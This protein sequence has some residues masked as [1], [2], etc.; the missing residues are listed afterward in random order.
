MAPHR[1][2][3]RLGADPLSAHASAH[4]RVRRL[5]RQPIVAAPGDS[6]ALTFLSQVLIGDSE[7]SLAEVRQL[8]A[9][10]ERARFDHS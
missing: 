4:R 1:P 5:D 10:R 6:G 9:L 8:V 2:T 7:W 3:R